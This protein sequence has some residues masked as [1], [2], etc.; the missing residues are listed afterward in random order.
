MQENWTP[1]HFAVAEGHLDVVEMLI[2]LGAETASLTNVSIAL[3]GYV[4]S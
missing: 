3:W 4:T 2:K 1:L